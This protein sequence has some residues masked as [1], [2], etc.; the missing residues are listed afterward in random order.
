MS[1]LVLL[2]A[3]AVI[4][5]ILTPHQA[6]VE[7]LLAAALAALWGALAEGSPPLRSVALLAVAAA[8]AAGASPMLATPELTAIP[9]STD[10]PTT[11]VVRW[12]GTGA[13]GP[14]AWI[15]PA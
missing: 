13:A 14:P 11:G 15:A 12:A 1:L 4:G 7:L 6:P 2:A 3:A 10:G 9:R 8:L 5:R